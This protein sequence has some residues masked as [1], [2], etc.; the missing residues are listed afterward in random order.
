VWIG[1]E[2]ELRRIGGR[3]RAVA[4]GRGGS[5]LVEGEPGMGKTSLLAR[6]AEEAGRLGCRVFQAA[7]DEFGQRFP[8][9]TVLEWMDAAEQA[10]HAPRADIVGMLSDGTAATD[11]LAVAVAGRVLEATARLCAAAPVV[12]VVDDL[13]WADEASL[14]VWHRLSRATG[15]LPLLLLAAA[16]P[17]PGDAP[18]G[19]D[20][21]APGRPELAHFR[22][23]L[24]A[25]GTELLRLGAMSA[26]E[27]GALAEA[28]LGAPAGQRLRERLG[29]AGGNPLYIR[30]LIGSLTYADG[31]EVAGGAAELAPGVSARQEPS[32]LADRLDAL[33]DAT[34]D[35]LRMASLLGGD[36][37]LPELAALTRRSPGD[38]R[39][40]LDEAVA[41]GAVT[42]SG[43]RLAFRHALIRQGLHDTMP[44]SLRAALHRQAAQALAGA[45]AAMEAVAGQ[46]L[47]TEGATDGWTVEWLAANADQLTAR[48]PTV[49]AELLQR[50][51]D[52]VP[53]HDP[54]LPALEDRLSTAAYLLRRPESF[55][56]LRLL[57]D[58]A[59]DPERRAALTVMLAMG[60]IQHGD[61]PGALAAMEE[62]RPEPSSAW[63]LRFRSMR[64]FVLWFEGRYE[65]ARALAREVLTAA[66]QAGDALATA[67]TRH[68]LAL[69][70]VRQRDAEGALKESELALG[71]ADRALEAAE[72]IYKD[73]DLRVILL[74]NRATTLGSLDRLG[75]AWQA[76]RE[77]RELAGTAG[78][79]GRIAWTRLA[80]AA[81][82]YWTGE[83]DE[84]LADLETVADLP[85]IDWMPVLRC[86]ISALVLGHRDLGEQARAQLET[87]GGRAVHAG[88][89]RGYSSYL[90]MARALLAERDGNPEEALA[91]LAPTL[92]ADHARDLE[93]RHRWMPDVVRLA[94]S[95]GD[96]GRAQAAA[97]VAAAE[98]ARMTGHRGRVAA[99]GRC[100]GLLD[101]DPS[102][103]LAAVA[104]YEET[105]RPPALAAALEDLA[106]VTALRGEPEAARAHLHRAVDVYSS[107]GAAWDVARADARLRALG[108]RRGQRTRRRRAGSGW[109]ALTPTELRVAALVREGRSNPEIAAALLLSPRTVQ[110][111]VSHI[112]GKLGVRSRSE[113]AREAA[114]RL[115]LP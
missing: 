77:A 45:G 111:H 108:V 44:A 115:P 52:H 81:L 6:A 4:R 21:P 92:D 89:E 15:E 32:P 69:V 82:R 86:G 70:L 33:P 96:T 56:M 55:A 1:R 59:T 87:V 42:E 105:A 43:P 18:A 14:L 102:P 57:R 7:A 101:G 79:Y 100:R 8:L 31:I 65:Q 54:R 106:A 24:L 72:G 37:T 71:A 25:R 22:G 73:T 113:V 20:V 49:A 99:A 75:E 26:Q 67:Y 2:E 10:W 5:V 66:E 64:A 48:A 76:L 28:L 74:I 27:A 112:L 29:T 80:S 34:L 36:F 90:I 88:V 40:A 13:Q 98:A 58:R 78:T 9:R 38:L 46:L 104:Y 85:T 12:L 107:L 60:M 95:V 53:P 35:M 30:E 83:W 62:E 47:H 3:V 114:L 16:R 63:D 103:L 19:G 97:E 84:V 41:A 51:V 61:Y 94:L 17:H 110:T 91:V 109:E 11:A 68:V 39:R 93:H 50:A 23:R